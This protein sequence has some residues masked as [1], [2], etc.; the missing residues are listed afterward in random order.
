MEDQRAAR[1]HIIVNI[2]STDFTAHHAQMVIDLKNFSELPVSERLL[3]SK[4]KPKVIQSLIHAADIGST[5]RP[6]DIAS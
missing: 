2:L 4:N 3:D 1:K 6:F 5:S